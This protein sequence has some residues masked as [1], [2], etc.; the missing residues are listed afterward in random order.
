LIL[1]LAGVFG[2]L[3]ITLSS[4]EHACPTL[5]YTLVNSLSMKGHVCI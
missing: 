2:F 1:R 4:I 3:Q 5:N